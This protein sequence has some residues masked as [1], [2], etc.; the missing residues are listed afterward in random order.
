MAEAEEFDVADAVVPDGFAE[1]ALDV[2]DSEEEPAD[3]AERGVESRLTPGVELAVDAPGL[4]E[5][6]PEPE[7]FASAGFLS[8][9]GVVPALG[10]LVDAL[11]A[12]G[13]PGFS[14]TF[15]AFRSIVTGRLEPVPEPL[16]GVVPLPGLS[17]APL[18][19]PPEEDVPPEDFLSVAI[20]S[21]PEP[22]GH[23]LYTPLG[24]AVPARHVFVALQNNDSTGSG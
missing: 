23:L 12:P 19:F 18:P 15:S 5:A 2:P 21:P 4:E 20:Y 1:S 24:E 22:S 11:E 16:A 10:T 13:L 6:G 8:A 9:A 17:E 3:V 7:G 14:S